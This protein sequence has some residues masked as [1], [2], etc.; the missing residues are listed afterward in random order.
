MESI[1][2]EKRKQLKQPLRICVDC[3]DLLCLDGYVDS[4]FVV[5]RTTFK[6][7]VRCELCGESM[8]CFIIIPHSRGIYICERCLR[9][10]TATSKHRWQAW[11]KR[12]VSSGE[13]KCDLCGGDARYHIVLP[14]SRK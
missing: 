7:D 10:L 3:L 11:P 9:S 14:R 1:V 12:V 6:Q 5:S 13:K 8:A 4:N 2:V